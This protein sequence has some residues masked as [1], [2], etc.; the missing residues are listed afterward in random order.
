VHKVE[1]LIATARSNKIAVLLGLQELPQLKQQYGQETADTICSVAAN[2]ISGSVRNKETL[3]WLEKLFGKVR[4]QREGISIDGSSTSRSMDEEMGDLIPAS[5]IAT[6]AAGEVVAQVAFDNT[7]Y[8][9]QHVNSTYNCKINLDV[10]FIS[11]EE[12][13]YVNMPIFY[14]FGDDGERNY[15]LDQNFARINREIESLKDHFY[16]HELNHNRSG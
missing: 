5:K 14:N 13:L 3:D 10:N 4:Q 16:T 9:G 7:R 15:I 1:N 6:L 2:V 11:Q 12:E 8:D